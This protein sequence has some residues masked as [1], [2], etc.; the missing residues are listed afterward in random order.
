MAK[1]AAS[2]SFM[3]GGITGFTKLQSLLLCYYS[4]FIECW[5]KNV[6]E[7]MDYDTSPCLNNFLWE[8]LRDCDSVPS[9]GSSNTSRGSSRSSNISRKTS[10]NSL[11]SL[12]SIIEDNTGM[13]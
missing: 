13:P 8:P 6:M 12:S 7:I 10:C 1:A 3:G 4:P 5:L 2:A 9:L 11:L